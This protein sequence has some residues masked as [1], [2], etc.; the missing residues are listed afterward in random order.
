MSRLGFI[1]SAI[2]CI[3]L[4]SLGLGR[5]IANDNDLLIEALLHED[6]AKAKTL[7]ENGADVNYL[8]TKNNE[9][10]TPLIIVKEINLAQL[11]IS[12]GANVNKKTPNFERTPLTSAVFSGDVELAKLYLDHGADINATTLGTFGHETALSVALISPNVSKDLVNLLISRGAD[13]NYADGLGHT[14]LMSACSKRG[15]STIVGILLHAKARVNA[16]DMD[17]YSPLMIAAFRGDARMVGI[18]IQAGADVNAK[19]KKGESVLS[20]AELNDD[21]TVS[22]ELVRAGAKR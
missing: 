3:T 18:L 8:Y 10:Y 7:I 1:T 15:N 19:N 4:I 2:A 5:A 11:L 9:E 17:G 6:F 22:D 12:K 13:A 14:P 16:K 20:L 21:S